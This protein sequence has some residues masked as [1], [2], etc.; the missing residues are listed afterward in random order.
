MKESLKESGGFLPADTEPPEVLKQSDSALDGPKPVRLNHN[1]H[2]RPFRHP[3]ASRGPEPYGGT[4]TRTHWIPAC[5]GMTSKDGPPAASGRIRD[6]FRQPIEL[7]VR[8]H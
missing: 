2:P 8:E 4:T 1:P 7:R 6:P 5:A 3:C